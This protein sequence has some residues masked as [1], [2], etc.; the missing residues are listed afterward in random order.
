[1]RQITKRI[2]S[3]EPPSSENE[4]LD[5]PILQKRALP[6]LAARGNKAATSGQEGRDFTCP[7][8]HPSHLGHI[9][10]ILFGVL[11]DFKEFYGIHGLN[12]FGEFFG[13]DFFGVVG[14]LGFL[15]LKQFVFINNFLFFQGCRKVTLN[16]IQVFSG[17]P[18]HVRNVLISS[19]RPQHPMGM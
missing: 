9:N 2:A 17:D 6:V 1:M 8:P 3:R 18:T 5:G 16:D 14:F 19:I 4:T 13:L 15:R 7:K 12:G 11:N 10:P